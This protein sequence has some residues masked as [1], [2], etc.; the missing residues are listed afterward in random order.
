VYVKAAAKKTPAEYVCWEN[1]D[2]EWGWSWSDIEKVIALWEQGN[3]VEE[4]SNALKRPLIEVWLLLANLVWSN[5][6]KPKSKIFC[7]PYSYRPKNRISLGR[8]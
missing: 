4:I 1:V 5:I 2:V 7:L 8:D 3:K 6:I